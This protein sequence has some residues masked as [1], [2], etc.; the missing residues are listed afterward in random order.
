MRERT[1]SH[2]GELTQASYISLEQDNTTE[3]GLDDVLL[4]QASPLSL[5]HEST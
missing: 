5:E 3:V 4:S 2:P 1:I